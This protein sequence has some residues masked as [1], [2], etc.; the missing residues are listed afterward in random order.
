MQSGDMRIRLHLDETLSSDTQVTFVLEVSGH[1]ET[2]P[3]IHGAVLKH[4]Q[5]D[6]QP[7]T[8]EQL[9]LTAGRHL[10]SLER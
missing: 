5:W 1:A 8:S 7:I 10:L 2:P 6:G 4:M 3:Q 9:S